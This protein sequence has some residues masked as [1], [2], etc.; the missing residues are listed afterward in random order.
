MSK[1]LRDILHELTDN[2]VTA[3][4]LDFPAACACGVDDAAASEG[5]G[6][7]LP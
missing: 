6:E 4:I 1:I 3:I 7:S 5:Q 2:V